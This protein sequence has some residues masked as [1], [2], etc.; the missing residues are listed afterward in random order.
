MDKK[1]NNTTPILV[2]GGTGYLASWIIKKLLDEGLNVRTTVRDKS[3]IEKSNHLIKLAEQ[4]KG[5]LEFFE[6]D[7]LI[8]KSFD[9]AVADCE[10]VFHTASPFQMY[11]IKN[12]Q[13]QLVEPAVN[14]TKNVLDSI[15]KTNSV[16][17][18]VLTSS[19][20]AIYQNTKDTFEQKLNE[21]SWNNVSSLTD[22]PYMFSKKIAEE[23]AWKI[24]KSQD[25]WD[26]ITINPGFILGPS[27]SNRVDSFSI[28]FMLSML[29]GKNKYGVPALS[30]PVVDVRDV[31]KSQILGAFLPE[32]S[33]R[34]IIVTDKPLCF[35][36][37]AKVLKKEYG[38]KYPIPT[39]NLP[40]FIL[41]IA[42]PFMK[43]KWSYLKNN[44]GFSANLDNSY[45]IKDLGMNYR[46][47]E[48][49]IID[50]ANQIIENG[51]LK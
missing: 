23:I 51:L 12:P 6:A 20:A 44:L 39:K 36:D 46:S 18:V 21:N 47:I 40:N 26:L 42:A 2:T 10:L 8:E 24:A 4:S 3:N 22:N 49:T 29:N 1:I 7:L 16:K 14:G 50:H 28:D 34:H 31:A 17:R 5:S 25:R 11:N 13:K 19:T 15:N 30:F 33:G 43:M 27:L 32:A 48:K 38:N 45:S 35:L 9:Q 41:Y 37:I